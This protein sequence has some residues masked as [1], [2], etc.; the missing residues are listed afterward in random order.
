MTEEDNSGSSLTI[1]DDVDAEIEG[2]KL[3]VNGEEYSLTKIKSEIEKRA[4]DN[5]P[6]TVK[7]GG[8]AMLAGASLAGP[9]GG[10]AG[11]V[12]GGGI[13]YLKDEGYIGGQDE[14]EIE[15]IDLEAVDDEGEDVSTSDGFS[16]NELP[17]VFQEYDEKWYRPDSDIYALAIRT[18][19]GDRAYFETVEGAQQRLISEY[20]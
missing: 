12:V 18:P 14:P 7:L 16:L 13:G 10:F 5:A 4:K 19:D 6:W 17:E 11:A 15:E 20:A 9:P 3:I 2:N 8:G 1:P